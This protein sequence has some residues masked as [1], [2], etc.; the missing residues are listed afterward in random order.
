MSRRKPKPPAKSRFP[1]VDRAD[2]RKFAAAF[3]VSLVV[4]GTYWA[5]FAPAPTEPYFD[6]GSVLNSETVST[7]AV[8]TPSEDEI[9]V[10]EDLNPK[11][12]APPET[13]PPS[14]SILPPR[15]KRRALPSKLSFS[16]RPDSTKRDERVLS[17][18]RTNLLANP[19][20]P[21]VLPLSVT[22][23]SER[24]EPRGQIVGKEL[25]MSDSI[26]TDSERIKVLVHELG[27]MVDVHYFR[28]SAAADVSDAFYGISWDSYKV[29]KKGAKLADFVSGYALSNKY[30]DFA[31][32]FAFYV[33]HNAEFQRRARTNRSL[34]EKYRFLSERVFPNE[35]FVSTDFGTGKL[36]EYVWDTTKP[37]IDTKKYLFYIK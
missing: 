17:I 9:F 2:V 26:P 31:E 30:E 15:A 35:E 12:S 21:K 25:I 16:F 29:K 18:L 24:T 32:S 13:L 19:F 37:S 36:K 4:S 22:V 27:H 11:E 1:T 3:S 14:E 10:L 33:F 23:D 28:P 5:F 7:G 8:E 6:S 34:A 20:S